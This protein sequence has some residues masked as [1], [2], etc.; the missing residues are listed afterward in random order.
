MRQALHFQSLGFRLHDTMIYRKLNPMPL[1]HN[2]YEQEWEYVF[3][4]SLGKPNVWNPLL[5]ANSSAGTKV[6]WSTRAVA[7][8][9]ARRSREEVTVT[10]EESQRG[11]VFE[12]VIAKDRIGDHPA[13]FPTE[14]ASD[15][16]LSWSN[17]GEI[18]LDPF[19][20][21]GTTAKMAR[22]LGRRFI[23]IEV[24]QEYCDI[25]QKRLAQGLLW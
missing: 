3:V 24:N 17:E 7:D 22:E 11:N 16:I 20:G 6:N 25:S 21:S 5:R 13:P 9:A 4:F 10:K 12:Y 8:N 19:S 15:V 1:T 18:V 14:F 23:G 2:R